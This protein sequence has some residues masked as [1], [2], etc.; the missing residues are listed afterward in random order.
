MFT[1]PDVTGSCSPSFSWPHHL[2][3]GLQ[4]IEFQSAFNILVNCLSKKMNITALEHQHHT[5]WRLTD[6]MWACVCTVKKKKKL[7]VL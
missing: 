6:V 7:E 3:N 2:T 5:I 1:Q 4:F